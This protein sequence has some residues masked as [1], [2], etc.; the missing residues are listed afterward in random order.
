MVNIEC[1][2]L[3]IEWLVIHLFFFFYFLFTLRVFHT[4]YF[5]SLASDMSL[6]RPTAVRVMGKLFVNFF[7]INFYSQVVFDKNIRGF[8]D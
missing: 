3:Y 5:H 2:V 8:S 4:Q 7:F 1:R 6:T